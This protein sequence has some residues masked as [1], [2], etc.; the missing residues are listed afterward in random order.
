MDSIDL[1][2]VQ[3]GLYAGLPHVLRIPLLFLALGAALG[4]PL[5]YYLASTPTTTPTRTNK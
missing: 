4:L 2:A 3:L 1:V 5:G